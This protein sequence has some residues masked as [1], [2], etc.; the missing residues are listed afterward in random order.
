ME[1]KL[2][3]SETRR[4]THQLRPESTTD[5]RASILKI[6]PEPHVDCSLLNP[7]APPSILAPSGVLGEVPGTP[8]WDACD[9]RCRVCEAT[10]LML[11]VD[12]FDPR[13][14]LAAPSSLEA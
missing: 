13:S 6:A 2:K 3:D 8:A 9:S 4:T 11:R 5:G 7:H 12:N 14:P 10:K 1:Q